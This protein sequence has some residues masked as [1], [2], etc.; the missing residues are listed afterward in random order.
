MLSSSMSQSNA[1]AATDGVVDDNPAAAPIPGKNDD[2]SAMSLGGARE[3]GMSDTSAGGA[4][5][6]HAS[7]PTT[8]LAAG[9]SPAHQLHS[10]ALHLSGD[11]V[12]G[13]PADAGGIHTPT[14]RGSI[15]LPSNGTSQ[16]SAGSGVASGQQTP[17]SMGRTVPGGGHLDLLRANDALETTSTKQE[18]KSASRPSSPFDTMQ[19]QDSHNNNNNNNYN[20]EQRRRRLSSRGASSAAASPHASSSPLGGGGG[21]SSQSPRMTG[22]ASPRTA[23]S[24]LMS[25]TSSAVSVPNSTSVSALFERDVEHTQEHLLSE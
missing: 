22:Y 8:A 10:P 19:H 11:A 15:L 14:S 16:P 1:A 17:R 25:S 7:S 21:S 2:G 20:P 9:L 4:I 23:N 12:L 24:D 18:M 13:D 5:A 6:R 3:R